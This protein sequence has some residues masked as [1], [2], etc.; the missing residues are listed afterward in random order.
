MGEKEKNSI[1]RKTAPIILPFEFCNTC[2][3]FSADV[4]NSISGP[5]I[6][7]YHQKACMEAVQGYM[8]HCVNIS[9]ENKE[10]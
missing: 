7:C 4:E 1:D 8:F 2:T 6:R 9:F 10:D 5:V 3:Q